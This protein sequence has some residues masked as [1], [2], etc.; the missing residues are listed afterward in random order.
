MATETKTEM[1]AE[2]KTES[3]TVTSLDA[4]NYEGNLTLKFA[5][6]KS[7]TLSKNAAARSEFL[8]AFLEE[9]PDR[10]ETD[11]PTDDSAT[12][13]IQNTIDTVV[14]YLVHYEGKTPQDPQKPLPST[15][16][17]DA[18]KDPFD[19]E[20]LEQYDDNKDDLYRLTMSS[21]KL[22]LKH[23]ESLTLAKI[24]SFIKGKPLED[25]PKILRPKDTAMVAVAD[26][27]KKLAEE[28]KAKEDNAE[29]KSADSECK[30]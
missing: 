14:K 17:K 2:T 12:H 1:K 24:A 9:F 3:N 21:V 22:G 8:R 19:A 11:F 18:V 20:L 15:N 26:A 29:S 27:N 5:G 7:L 25:I 10:N 13:P 30:A 6:G 16:L 28:N 23:L 4:T